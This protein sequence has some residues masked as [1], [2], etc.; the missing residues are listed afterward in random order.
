MSEYDKEYQAK[1][2]QQS[3]ERHRIQNAKQC[4]LKYISLMDNPFPDEIPIVHHHINNMFIVPVPWRV[5]SRHPTENHR[6][7]VNNWIEEYIGAVGV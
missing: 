1:Y 3:K 2:Y 7:N 6:R 4:G 5:H